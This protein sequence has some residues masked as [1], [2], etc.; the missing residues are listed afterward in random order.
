MP[1][2]EEELR[3]SLLS[4]EF[5]ISALKLSNALKKEFV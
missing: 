3:I 2:L 1:V 5:Q 4:K